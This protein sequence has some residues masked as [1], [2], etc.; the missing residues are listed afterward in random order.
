MIPSFLQVTLFDNGGCLN[1]PTVRYLTHLTN[2]NSL[3]LLPPPSLF[4]R[5]PNKNLLNLN[6]L[7]RSLRL[8]LC[9]AVGTRE[10]SVH[11]SHPPSQMS[12]Q[13]GRCNHFQRGQG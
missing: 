5:Y 6:L 13:K 7:S 3:R 11:S 8:L 12:P 4:P 2:L 1:I 10:A 9:Q